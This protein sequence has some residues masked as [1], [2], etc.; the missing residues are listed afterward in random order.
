[1]IRS[2]RQPGMSI[3]REARRRDTGPILFNDIIVLVRTLVGVS[4][5]VTDGTAVGK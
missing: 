5:G 4:V 1:M 2:I 3:G